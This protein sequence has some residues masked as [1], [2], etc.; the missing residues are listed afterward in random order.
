MQTSQQFADSSFRMFRSNTKSNRYDKGVSV[1]SGKE[2]VRLHKACCRS[3]EAFCKDSQQALNAMILAELL[4]NDIGKQIALD[5]HLKG[6][7]GAKHN[8]ERRR[9]DLSEFIAA[10][11]GTSVE[12]KAPRKRRPRKS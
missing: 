3:L 2:F 5:F 8:Y 7:I 4:P 9:C 1:A 12:K 6:E 10:R 11:V